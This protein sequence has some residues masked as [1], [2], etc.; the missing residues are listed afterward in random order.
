VHREDALHAL[1]ERHLA[2]REGGANAAAAQVDH[3]AFEDLNPFL[4][5][6]LD[7]HVHA[8]RVSRLHP[9]PLD[10]LRLLHHL[11]RGHDN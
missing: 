2:H 6:F 1:T 7:A 11:H 5:A 9:R 4:V 8:H 3:H 10:E